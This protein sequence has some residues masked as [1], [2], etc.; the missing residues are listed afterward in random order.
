[1]EKLK[2]PPIAEEEISYGRGVK[3][4]SPVSIPSIS[5]WEANSIVTQFIPHN[6]ESPEKR[7]RLE[8]RAAT[9]FNG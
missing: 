7:K 1:M 9:V 4:S 5:L 8:S 6:I 2:W 3:G